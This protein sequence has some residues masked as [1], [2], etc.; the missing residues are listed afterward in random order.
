[1]IPLRSWK[2]GRF[3][4]IFSFGNLIVCCGSRASLA[5]PLH[6]PPAFLNLHGINYTVIMTQLF[7]IDKF[8]ANA[9]FWFALRRR[10]C[11]DPPTKLDFVFFIALPWSRQKIS[12]KFVATKRYILNS[13]IRICK[14][15]FYDK[16]NI[17][18]GHL[19]GWK[20]EVCLRRLSTWT[21]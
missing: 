14:E 4:K 16:M 2:V 13:V 19:A 10:R 1:M 5:P 9:H 17:K 21:G 3:Q 18:R 20:I 8:T 12:T 11:G 7:R 6:T 15:D